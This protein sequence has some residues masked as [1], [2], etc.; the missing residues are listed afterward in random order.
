M[1]SAGSR[2]GRKMARLGVKVGG[3]SEIGMENTELEEGEACSYRNN[4]ENNIDPDDLTYIDE[5]LQNVLGHF[6]KD[7]EG[8][9]FT[10]TLGA[11]YGGYGS[12]L[13]QR[14]PVRSYSRSPANIQISQSHKSPTCLSAEG[15]NYSS[16][17]P[18]SAT[19][20]YAS[21]ELYKPPSHHGLAR[22]I[23]QAP[24]HSTEETTAKAE[25]VDKSANINEQRMLKVRIKVGSDNLS[26]KKKAAIYSG[27]GLVSPSSSLDDSPTVS[28]G[29]SQSFQLPGDESPNQIIRLM[30]SLPIHGGQLLSPLPEALARLT[31]KLI[32]DNI[33]EPALRHNWGS[34]GL[35]SNGVAAN[36]LPIEDHIKSKGK[37][38]LP[39][40]CKKDSERALNDVILKNQA[41]LGTQACDE[42]VSEALKLP[43]LSDFPGTLGEKRGTLKKNPVLLSNASRHEHLMPMLSC[44]GDWNERQNVDE[45]LPLKIAREE[46]VDLQNDVRGYQ[47]KDKDSR[48]AAANSSTNTDTHDFDS[49]SMKGSLI[50]PNDSRKLNNGKESM[51]IEQKGMDL[52]SGGKQL[53]SGGK[54]KEK[55]SRTTGP[56]ANEI[57][58]GI[59]QN[60]FSVDKDSSM[61]VN[62]SCKMEIE[63]FPKKKDLTKVK[64]T[65]KDFFGDM[66]EDGGDSMDSPDEPSTE[67]PKSYL[68]RDSNSR[69]ISSKGDHEQL[70]PKVHPKQ[71]SDFVLPS[72]HVPPIGEPASAKSSDENW[73]WV[74]CDKCSKW[75]LLPFG[76]KGDSLPDYWLCSMLNWLSGMSSCSI[77]EE[78]T[79]KAVARLYQ[80]QN[81]IGVDAILSDA[82]PGLA[83]NVLHPEKSLPINFPGSGN[84]HDLKEVPK[85]KHFSNNQNLIVAA[86]SQLESEPRVHH[87]KKSTD[88][89]LEANQHKNKSKKKHLD[90]YSKGG[91]SKNRKPEGLGEP[92]QDHARVSKKMKVEEELWI[93]HD[94]GNEMLIPSNDELLVNGAQKYQPLNRECSYQSSK[95]H[96]EDT[97]QNSAKKSKFQAQ[98]SPHTDC[99]DAGNDNDING[100]AK[101]RK[102][103]SSL[104]SPGSLT[105]K[106]FN[107]NDETE[108]KKARIS[109]PEKKVSSSSRG[110]SRTD[111]KRK[112]TKD[113]QLGKA[114]DDHRSLN[115]E[116]G[117]AATSSSSKVSYSLRSN[118]IVR[119]VKSSPVESV[120]SS[121]LRTLDSDKYLSGIQN[122]IEKDSFHNSEILAKDDPISFADRKADSYGERSGAMR[123]KLSGNNNHQSANDLKDSLVGEE[124]QI[125]HSSVLPPVNLAGDQADLLNQNNVNGL[126]L[127]QCESDYSRSRSKNQKFKSEFDK[128]KVKMSDNYDVLQDHAHA[129][130]EKTKD[131]RIKFQDKSGCD[132]GSSEMDFVVKK[133]SSGILLDEQSKKDGMLKPVCQEPSVAKAEVSLEMGSVA[134]KKTNTD[135][136]KKRSKRFDQ[137]K[138]EEMNLHKGKEKAENKNCL[139]NCNSSP[140]QGNG[141]DASGVNER[142]DGKGPKEHM[143]SKK[144]A[145]SNG[146]HSSASKHQQP[147]VHKAKDRDAPSPMRRDSHNQAASNA[148]KEATVL[149]HLADRKKNSGSAESTG[150]YFEAALKFLHGACLFESSGSENSKRGDVMQSMQVYSDT[151]KLC[152]F[153]AHEYEMSK[154]LAC[155]ALAYKCVE[156]AYLR[157]IYSSHPCASRDRRELQTSLQMVPP[158]ESPSSSA[159]DIDNASNLATA[160]KAAQAR[161][162]NSPQPAGNHVIA[163]S[164]RPNFGRLMKYMQDVNSAMEASRKSQRAFSAAQAAMKQADSK[165]GIAF[166]KRVVNFNFHDVE[167]LLRIVRLALE[168]I[169][170]VSTPRA[171]YLKIGRND[172]ISVHNL[173]IWEVI[174]VASWGENSPYKF[175][176]GCRFISGGEF[177]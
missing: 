19:I 89:V 147:N 107:E 113:H 106:L 54:K 52:P 4:E 173:E 108:Q 78:E 167:G 157:V 155:A 142:D 79:T 145:M 26:A 156:V 41:D 60:T 33:A 174:S 69:K 68:V 34:S 46:K 150:L 97:N 101:K 58:N 47:N 103:T 67:R 117:S 149:K 160:E 133:S 118:S 124:V 166:V 70:M 31:E 123:K 14:S 159:S 170:H 127:K 73:E 126:L 11:K 153:C 66:M 114:V 49:K 172:S 28:E 21:S 62:H 24:K 93:S 121:P 116:L 76:T 15:G 55:G 44:D 112:G 136:G 104:S 152:E 176:L 175:V 56:L 72:Q 22:Q 95:C 91:H 109:M 61:A 122:V 36:I 18:E 87:S 2:D 135:Y 144:S 48:G 29:L 148:L 99:M 10:E 86:G 110:N 138:D 129:L 132:A 23:A 30:T 84:K 82:N 162:G 96:T 134:E 71:A 7:F 25:A 119:D 140:Y 94:M 3:G 65:Y 168:A 12:F 5:K 177:G 90:K 111:K 139:P 63:S 77:A 81:H 57:Y 74:Q 141:A 40:K 32:H 64:D 17:N 83:A 6:K 27:L 102:V 13:I 163:A 98:A 131:V 20:H 75:R 169:K 143:P 43:L 35:K 137:D 85:S 1:I 38:H 16:M 164:N 165:D 9:V 158:G 128:G 51:L 125:K 59:V 92:N 171:V 146:V 53:C 161:G 88:P 50:A 80:P 8:G 151:A 42:V 115:R 39:P 100:V 120:S 45:N 105:G 130:K 37:N 154:N